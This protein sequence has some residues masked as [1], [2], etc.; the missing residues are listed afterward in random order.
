LREGRGVKG[1]EIEVYLW[2]KSPALGQEKSRIRVILKAK[3][4]ALQF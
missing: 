3:K 4:F 1:Q 2:L